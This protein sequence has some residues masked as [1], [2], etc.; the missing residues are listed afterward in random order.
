[1]CYC[2]GERNKRRVSEREN[3]IRGLG[4]AMVVRVGVFF[5]F[6]REIELDHICI[7]DLHDENLLA[8]R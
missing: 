6:D 5:T 8:E 4:D 1:M 2:V 7:T 3:L